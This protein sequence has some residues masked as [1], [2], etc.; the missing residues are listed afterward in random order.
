MDKKGL[1]PSRT[2]RPSLRHLGIC[3]VNYPTL[4]LKRWAI[5]GTSLRDEEDR[6][7]RFNCKSAIATHG[8]EK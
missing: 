4:K 1:N 8:L 6:L 3:F 5:V 2:F 7:A